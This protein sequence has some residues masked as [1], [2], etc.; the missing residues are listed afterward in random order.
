M[1]RILQNKTPQDILL[2]TGETH[3]VREFIELSFKLLDIKLEWEGENE[4]EKGID[5]ATGKVIVK[6]DPKYYRLTEVHILQ[7]DASK[8]KQEIGWEAKIKFNKLVEIMIK[9]D[10]DLLKNNQ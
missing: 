8:A 5:R 2:A 9:S 3:S 7:G 6:I 4:Y 10:W 1:W